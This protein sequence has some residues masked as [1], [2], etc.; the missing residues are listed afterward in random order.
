LQRNSDIADKTMQDIIAQL[1][2]KRARGVG[3]RVKRIARRGK[4]AG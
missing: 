3:R 1:Q 2:H 4:V